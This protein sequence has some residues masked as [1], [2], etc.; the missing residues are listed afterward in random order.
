[1]QNKGR[2]CHMLRKTEFPLEEMVCGSLRNGGRIRRLRQPTGSRQV[3][4]IL[5]SLDRPSSN[6]LD[7]FLKE[8]IDVLLRGTRMFSS[9]FAKFDQRLSTWI[10]HGPQ[11]R[12]V[13]LR[14]AAEIAE[15][16][17]CYRRIQEK[18]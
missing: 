16:L 5:I 8:S 14:V 1:M 9:P 4:S 13:D 18:C 7:I 17:I 11:V 6:P 2:R 12:R 10:S 15:M 3:F